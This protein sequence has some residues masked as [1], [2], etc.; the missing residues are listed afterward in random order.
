MIECLSCLKLFLNLL[1][2]KSFASWII[3]LH[4]KSK[5]MQWISCRSKC[6]VSMQWILLP[7][8]ENIFCAY[9]IAQ[10]FYFLPYLCIRK[11]IGQ[12]QKYSHKQTS[13]TR[14]HFRIN[15]KIYRCHYYQ[16]STH[17]VVVDQKSVIS[18]WVTLKSYFNAKF[19]RIIWCK[20]FKRFDGISIDIITYHWVSQIDALDRYF[21]ICIFKLKL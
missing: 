6:R 11:E 5:P 15:E 18:F 4:N 9:K 14:N 13:S 2:S 1:S 17:Q 8:S 10:F 16:H 20:A 3:S 7:H 12:N 19:S 21:I